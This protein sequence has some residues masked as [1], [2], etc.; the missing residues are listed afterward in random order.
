MNAM[1]A[2]TPSSFVEE[3]GSAMGNPAVRRKSALTDSMLRKIRPDLQKG[4]SEHKKQ[5]AHVTQMRRLAE[6]LGM[7]TGTYG[8]GILAVLPFGPAFSEFTL[9][10]SM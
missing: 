4:T 9:T 10:D 5:R 1:V 2:E 8:F 7:L 3:R 6:L